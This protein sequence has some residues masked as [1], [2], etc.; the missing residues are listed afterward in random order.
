MRVKLGAFAS[1]AVLVTALVALTGCGGSSSSSGG[2]N[3]GQ[4]S[5]TAIAVS[6]ASS[7]NVGDTAQLAASGTYSDGTT[8]DITSQ[9]TWITSP[10]TLA[11]VSTSGVLTGVTHGAVAVTASLSSVTS[12]TLSVNVVALLTGVSLNPIGPGIVVG[13]TQQFSLTG[14]FNDGSTQDVGS[15]A[16]WASS[17][18][19][20]ATVSGGL[21]T[22]I[23]PAAV[24]ITATAT[25]SN[26]KTATASTALDVVDPL[27]PTPSLSGDYAFALT[28]ADTRGPVF[29]AGSFTADGHG[30]ITGGIEDSN[31]N[32]G[33]QQSVALSGTYFVYPDGRGSITFNANAIYPSG[34]IY[35]FILSG[36]NTYGKVIQFDGRQTTKGY[37]ELQDP[38]SYK[39]SA[40]SGPYVFRLTGVD[41]G[42]KPMGQVG[43]M[44][45]DGGGNVTGG[46][47]DTNDYGTITSLAALTPRTYGM[48]AHGRG[49]VAIQSAN[50]NANFVLYA[51]NGS[52][53]NLMQLDAGASA[54][55][56]VTELQTGGPFS[57]SALTGSFAL[58][59]QRPPLVNENGYDRRE[60]ASIGSY[61]YDGAGTLSGT[62]DDANN[63]TSNPLVDIAGPYAASGQN[64]RGTLQATSS[65]NFR[66]YTFYMVNPA[67]MYM[68]QTYNS[69]TQGSLN[70]PV[71][72]GILQISAPYG[73]GSLSGAF[74]V[75]LSDLTVSYTEALMRMEF[76]GTGVVDGIADLSI[77]GAISSVVLN[78][79]YSI[80]SGSTTGRGA[81]VLPAPLGAN[82]YVF[83]L[84]SPNNAF[85][86]GINPDAQGNFTA[87]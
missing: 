64:G 6:G 57:N 35:R 85:L 32:G 56:G 61:S 71:G 28:S 80:K 75:D 36:G 82:S 11:T 41:A 43:Y 67:R 2:G 19:G 48:G 26:G 79:T 3:N 14:T 30:K 52:K 47:V 49:T 63:G 69:A 86:L 84:Y 46:S 78:A 58:Q 70:A 5:L 12:N 34:V 37:F 9:V 20:K 87:Q 74:T 54:L 45:L 83:Y 73:V 13:G 42:A 22:G 60:F 4:A 29:Y 39:V 55:A 72:L 76:D 7:V 68:L 24:T 27:I 10:S 33:V 25:L 18:K 21:A 77:N 1:A 16:T 23:G 66:A 40:F 51:V 53:A 15:S 38:S 81:I 44:T 50:G 65:L 59:L 62:R 17:D 8:K 31:S